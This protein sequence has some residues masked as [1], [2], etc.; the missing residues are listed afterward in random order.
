MKEFKTLKFLDK[1]KNFYEKLGVDYETMRLILKVK[2]TMD[3]R[4]T[5]TI[6]SNSNNKDKENKL[7]GALGLY[8]FL[9]FFMAV[10]LFM[11]LNTFLQM[12]IFFGFFMFLIGSIFISDFSYVLLDVRDTNILGVTSISPKTLSAAK[13]T[14][15]SIYILQ[16]SISYCGFSFL[17]S[18]KNGPIFTILFVLSIILLDIFMILITS[19]VYFLILKFFNGEKLKDII[20]IVQIILSVFIFLSY[21]LIGRI[22]NFIDVSANISLK[23]WLYFIPPAWFAA[24]FEMLTSG[25]YSTPLLILTSLSV[26]I[27]SISILI[28]SYISKSFEGYIQK[29]NNNTFKAKGSVP[30]SKR[31]STLICFDKVQRNFFNFTVNLIKGERNFKLKTY[32]LLAMAVL[33][34]FIFLMVD[35]SDFNS[36]SEFKNSLHTS[37]RYVFIYFTLAMIAPMSLMV[38]YSDNFKSAWLYKAVK[39]TNTSSLYKGIFK[40]VFYKLILPPMIFT[41]IIFVFLFG[42]P[43]LI[44]LI[45]A[46]ISLLILSLIVFI[47]MDKYLPFSVPFKDANN[48]DDLGVNLFAMV[49]AAI[50]GSFNY[51]LIKVQF[52]IYIFIFFQTIILILLWKF[53]F[54]GKLL[55]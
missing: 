7:N 26:I 15:I 18:L 40:G 31:I 41:T 17:V 43:V 34:P 10:T 3:T 11:P 50:L 8:A 36:F 37:N 24:P 25:N 52:G 23:P 39:I 33:F 22:Y 42:L 12:T 6:M 1:T 46:Y 14:H 21:Q 47:S 38:K 5:P 45:P 9:G 35:F 16:I 49:I 13:I 54:K 19:F 28:Y 53:S 4:R 30:I 20:N 55:K 27:P 2:L 29:L 44:K 48:M 32:P 51:F